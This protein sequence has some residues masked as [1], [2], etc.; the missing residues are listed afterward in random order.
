MK[1]NWSKLVVEINRKSTPNEWRA[2]GEVMADFVLDGLG[3]KSHRKRR[4]KN[5]TETTS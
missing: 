4:K 3:I 2:V 5:G 1:T